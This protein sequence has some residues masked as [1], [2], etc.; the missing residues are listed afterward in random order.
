MAMTALD[1]D[2]KELMWSALSGEKR[3]RVEEEIRLQKRLR[4]TPSQI[5]EAVV[6]LTR[7]LSVSSPTRA[8][9]SYLRPLRRNPPA[10]GRRPRSR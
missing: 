1:I 3:R 2:T 8:P 7:A 10:E 6:R 4:V 5:Q 9:Q